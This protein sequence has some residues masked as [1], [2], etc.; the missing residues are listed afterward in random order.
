MGRA[1]NLVSTVRDYAE[2]SSVHGVSYVFSRSQIYSTKE[3]DTGYMS[4]LKTLL[5]QEQTDMA[6]ISVQRLKNGVKSVGENVILLNKVVL[7]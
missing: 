1:R 7:G 4:S 3:L 5:K 2:A 6:D